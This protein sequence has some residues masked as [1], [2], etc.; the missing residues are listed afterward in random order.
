MFFVRFFV[1]E[2]FY[3]C[4]SRS[5]PYILPVALGLDSHNTPN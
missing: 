1:T 2:E 5:Y 4:Q 3:L